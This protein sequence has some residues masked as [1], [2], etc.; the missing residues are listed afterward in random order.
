MEIHP[1][2]RLIIVSTQMNQ[3]VPAVRYQLKHASRCITHTLGISVAYPFTTILILYGNM[4]ELDPEEA[5]D[6]ELGHW[7]NAVYRCF[8]DKGDVEDITEG[9]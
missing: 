1:V 9:Q 2:S 5:G 6:S 7:L 3:T 8:G 4:E